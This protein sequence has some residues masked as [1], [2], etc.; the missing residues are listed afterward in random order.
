MV[1]DE[2]LSRFI[3]GEL[4]EDE[5]VAVRNAI[6]A[7]AGLAARL[8]RLRAADRFFAGAISKIND[9]PLPEAAA[10]LLNEGASTHA[11][12]TLRQRPAVSNWRFP[13]ALA[14][15]FAVGSFCAAALLP[16]LTEQRAALAAGPVASKSHLADALG[17][18]P[19]GAS[20]FAGKAEVTPILSFRTADGSFCREFRWED[21]TA[22]VHGVACRTDGLWTVRVAAAQP[23][24][25]GYRP[26]STSPAVD[27]FV[28]SVMTG[29]PL[30]VDEERAFLTQPQRSGGK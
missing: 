8:E 11:V 4:A 10:T 22:G 26:A 18:L 20:L 28:E 1:T 2:E 7:D 25:D 27:S 21:G 15:S 9:H 23:T 17:S 16:G 6:A 3:D 19:S 29:D 14:A 12:A 24:T 5:A 13:V 30:S